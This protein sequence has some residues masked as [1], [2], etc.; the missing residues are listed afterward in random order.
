MNIYRVLKLEVTSDRHYA[1]FLCFSQFKKKKA[2][3]TK[4][5]RCVGKWLKFEST[6]ES[7]LSFHQEIGFGSI[8]QF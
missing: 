4:T 5:S 8:V 6:N 2:P 1:R 3:I 7:I